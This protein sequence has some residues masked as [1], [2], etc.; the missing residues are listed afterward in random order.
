MVFNSSIIPSLVYFNHLE[1]FFV[2]SRPAKDLYSGYV[3]VDTNIFSFSAHAE[4]MSTSRRPV[5]SGSRIARFLHIFSTRVKYEKM[6]SDFSGSVITNFL[7]SSQKI[8]GF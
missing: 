6:S 1:G 4:I 8:K 5:S 3:F 2:R 7:N